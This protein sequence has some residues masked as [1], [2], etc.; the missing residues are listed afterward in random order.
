MSFLVIS[1]FWILNYYMNT[2]WNTER[3]AIFKY[4][5]SDALNSGKRQRHIWKNLL[6]IFAKRKKVFRRSSVRSLK[7]VN[8]DFF[9]CQ[10]RNEKKYFT[11]HKKIIFHK[12]MCQNSEKTNC[13]TR[14]FSFY[15]FCFSK[16]MKLNLKLFYILKNKKVFFY[17]NFTCKHCRR[18]LMGLLWAKIFLIT[19][20]KL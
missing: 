15:V 14:L 13:L 19:I 6:F 10:T 8:F 1:K 12:K 4:L 9:K 5:Y 2:C 7:I 20:T 11:S 17:N 3:L 18:C 16:R